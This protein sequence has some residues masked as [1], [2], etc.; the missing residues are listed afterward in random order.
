VQYLILTHKSDLYYV[1]KQKR[2]RN[3]CCENWQSVSLYDSENYLKGQPI[4]GKVSDAKSYK[5]DIL[6]GYMQEM[7]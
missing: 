6:R 4:F 2:I 7:K 1:L 3:H 5:K